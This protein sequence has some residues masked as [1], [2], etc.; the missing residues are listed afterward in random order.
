MASAADNI[1]ARLV[2]F[3]ISTNLVTPAYKMIVCRI[4]GGLS[5]TAEVT[6]QDT[7]CGTS[8]ARGSA[9]YQVTGSFEAN[10]NP[11]VSEMSADELIALMESGAEFLWKAEDTTPDYYRAGQ[12]FF[13]SYNETFNNKESVLGDF[14]IEVNGSVDTTA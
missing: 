14:T 10:K 6:T 1:Q 9:N 4:N 7:T 13:S 12:G 3:S 5:A 2:A 11:G 8:K